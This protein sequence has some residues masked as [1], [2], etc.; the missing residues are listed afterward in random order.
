MRLIKC[1]ECQGQSPTNQ[2]NRVPVVGDRQPGRTIAHQLLAIANCLAA[3]TYRSDDELPTGEG[4]YHSGSHLC[5]DA[6][7]LL[8]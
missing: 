4:S 1:F 6:I 5:K 7:N 3:Q 8:A 2:D